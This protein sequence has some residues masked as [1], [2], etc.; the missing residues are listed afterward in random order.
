MRI[1]GET[2]QQA[3]DAVLADIKGLGGNGGLIAVA[4]S[5]ETA[6]G[7]TTP[8]DVSRR[9]RGRG[10]ARR[11]LLRTRNAVGKRRS[12]IRSRRR[13]L[14]VRR[15]GSRRPPARKPGSAQK[16][17]REGRHRPVAARQLV[18][19]LR[20][21]LDAGEAARD[22]RVDRL[23]IAELEMEE[24]HFLEGAPI[25]AVERLGADQVERAGD[26]PPSRSARISSSRS[27]MPL[28]E[29]VEEGAGQIGL[30]PFARAGVLVEGPEGVPMRRRR[31]RRRSG[32]RS[33]APRAP[34]ARSL[35]IA[36][37]LREARRRGNRRSS[38]IAA[39]S[40]WN[41]L[42]VR[43]SQPRR[44]NS[45]AASAASMKVAWAEDRPFCG[46]PPPRPPRS[47]PGQRRHRAQQPPARAPA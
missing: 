30:A 31:S 10:R 8:G 44:S 35:R 3:L 23:I 32:G 9:C 2:L 7:F 22:R 38:A 12:P 39:L 14:A 13:P 1:G 24:R 40:Q 33:P 16:M 47:A 34:R 19:A 46:R 26:R 20:A 41:W 15:R 5:G 27:P 37:R 29:Q 25:A 21:G 36:L 18:L 42:P 6:W 4:P 28:A 43:I 11:H 17:G 45:S